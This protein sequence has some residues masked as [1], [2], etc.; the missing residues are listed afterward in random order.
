MRVELTAICDQPTVVNL[1]Q[2]AY[3]NLDGSPDVLDHE[4][5]LACDFYTPSDAE[6]I[7]TGEIRAVAGTP[8]DFRE[9]RTIRNPTGQTYDTNFIASRA[10]G[11]D[12]LAWIAT[13]R[14]PKNGLT[15]E[16]S[17]GGAPGD[18]RGEASPCHNGLKTLAFAA[19]AAG[20]VRGASGG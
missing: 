8:Y 7:P 6:L 16:T 9:A 1:T 15:L 18:F 14:S 3:F 20:G 4:L 12:G 5:L 17:T 11:P 2:H 10:P 19:M 13:L